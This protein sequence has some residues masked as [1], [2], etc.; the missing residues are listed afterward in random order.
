MRTLESDCEPY[1]ASDTDDCVTNYETCIIYAC[2]GEQ[3][4]PIN[5]LLISS[6][7]CIRSGDTIAI[8][9]CESDACE[10]YQYIRL[11]DN[12][13][14]EVSSASV[15]CGTDSNCALLTYE[16]TGITQMISCW[17]PL[18]CLIAATECQTYTLL[19]GCVGD[20]ECAGEMSLSTAGMMLK[21][22]VSQRP[23]QIHLYVKMIARP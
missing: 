9:D 23:I 1:K 16:V 3:I 12:Q 17:N 5:Y 2:P 15:N 20:D 6:C 14:A 7:Y 19:E 21:N 8:G 11:M 13:D 22:S 10:G 18:I 4:V